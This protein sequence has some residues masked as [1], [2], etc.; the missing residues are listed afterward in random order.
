MSS[1][2]LQPCFMRIR[3]NYPTFSDKERKIADYI[4]ENPQNIIHGTINQVADDIGIADST[5]FRFC[6]RL[7]FKGYQAMKIALASEMVESMQD[8]HE[9]I[10]ADDNEKTVTEKVFHSNIKTLED[11]LKVVDEANFK[12]AVKTI[13]SAQRVEFFG[14]GGSNIIALDAYHKLIRTGVHVFAQT[15]THLQ[16][17]SASQLTSKDVAVLI[18]HTGT[19]KDI[20]Q[21]L[22]MS[23]ENG[24]KTVGITGFAKS[25]LSENVDIP[26]FTLSDE[27]DYRSEALASRIA[28]LTIIDAIYV[29]VMIARKGAGK[30]S[31][32]KVRNAISSKRL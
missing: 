25:P 2:D 5:V 3:S 19:T 26:I 7:G 15:D 16:L 23:K 18:S 8:I 14:C 10:Q 29:N 1:P 31:L 24:V 13:L 17:M 22:E 12:A 4:L 11:T 21:I 28:Q 27:T 30:K 20:L 9:K 32:Q 6:K